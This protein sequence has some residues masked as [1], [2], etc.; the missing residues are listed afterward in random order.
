MLSLND[1]AKQSRIF[2]GY[3]VMASFIASILLFIFGK[4]YASIFTLCLM[5]YF[6]IVDLTYRIEDIRKEEKTWKETNQ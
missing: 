4:T 6:A 5:N 1:L 2:I 3:F